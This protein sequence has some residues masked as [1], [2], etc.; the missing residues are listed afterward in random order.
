MLEDGIIVTLKTCTN[1]LK[2]MHTYKFAGQDDSISFGNVDYPLQD[3]GLRIPVGLT[4][5]A[6]I[7]EPWIF[8]SWT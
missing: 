1:L 5:Q 4:N 3:Q 8:T 2:K 6:S 7:W